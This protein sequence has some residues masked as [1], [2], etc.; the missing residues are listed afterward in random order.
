MIRFVNQ[1]LWT[2]DWLR[3]LSLRDAAAAKA[4]RADHGSTGSYDPWPALTV[5]AIFRAGMEP[6]AMERLR[7]LEPATREGPFGQ[8]HYVATEQYPVRKALSFGQDY[9]ASASGAFAEIILRTICG[10]APDVDDQWQWSPPRVP[11]FSG[12]L[13][14][15]RYKGRLLSASIDPR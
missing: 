9:F 6:E 11:G 14:N 5:E 2:T 13:I 1:E 7:S 4:T 8:A 10:F 3:S 12:R 15:L